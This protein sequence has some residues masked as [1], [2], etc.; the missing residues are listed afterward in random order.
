MLAC[1]EE[2]V[3]KFIAKSYRAVGVLE[4]LKLPKRLC[5]SISNLTSMNQVLFPSQLATGVWSSTCEIES[6]NYGV[7]LCPHWQVPYAEIGCMF[8]AWA[9]LCG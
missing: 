5:R 2:C 6:D 9:V 1:L 3:N 7:I 4:W 8:H